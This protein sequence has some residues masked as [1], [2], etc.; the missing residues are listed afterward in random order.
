MISFTRFILLV[1]MVCFSSL[2]TGSLIYSIRDALHGGSMA[3]DIPLFLNSLLWSGALV[4]GAT[5]IAASRLGDNIAALFFSIRKKS[6]REEE[7]INPARERIQ[8]LYRQKYGK[9]IDIK[10]YVMD[11]PH[12]NGMALG[13]RTVAISTGLLKVANDD[14]IASIIAHE[15]GHLHGGDGFLNM[16]ILTASFPTI[17]LNR[18]MNAFIFFGPKPR[19]LPSGGL[20][21]GWVAG[22]C[23]FLIFLMFIAY[24]IAFWLLSFPVLWLLRSVEFFTEWPIE[25]RAD[26]FAMELGFGP[27]MIEL[28]ERIE[29]EDIRNA[30]GFLSKYLYSHPPTALRIDQI[31]RSLLS[32]VQEAA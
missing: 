25:Y 24:L 26:R 28:F 22:L 3:L 1:V 5:L 2:F 18:L 30:T 31:E 8:Q 29:D 23:I 20:D 15:V 9:E 21:F 32:D 13:R 11:M 27:A 19:L 14:E 16:A 6:L 7:K 10:I 17:F 4:I 12:I